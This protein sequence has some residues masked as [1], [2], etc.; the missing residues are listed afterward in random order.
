[1]IVVSDE[2]DSSPAEPVSLGEF[3]EYMNGLRAD[4]DAVTFNSIVGPTEPEFPCGDV[5]APGLAYI[6]ATVGIGGVFWSL[7][8]EDW[9]GALEAMGL[10]ASGYLR[11]Y[12]LS[13]RPV[14]G[15]I[16]VTVENEGYTLGFDEWTE[17]DPTGDWVYNESRNSITF[18]TYV[19]PPSAVVHITYDVLSAVEEQ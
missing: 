18:L 8:D 5:S 3:I 7:C 14:D 17:E 4:P 12:P 11:E 6:Q 15:T 19:P 16:R 9:N 13:E 1:V 2:P 10:A